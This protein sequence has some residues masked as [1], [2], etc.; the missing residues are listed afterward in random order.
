MTLK[1]FSAQVSSDGTKRTLDLYK[2]GNLIES[3]PIVQAGTE[4]RSLILSTWVKS[5]QTVSTQKWMVNK[6]TY[7]LNEPRV[8]ELFWENSWV[9]T[10]DEEGY[11]VHAWICC[12][13][14]KLFHIY[15]SPELRGCKTATSLI[16]HFCGPGNVDIYKPWPF[17]SRG[18]L[19]NKNPY[20]ILQHP[21]PF[22]TSQES[23]D[24]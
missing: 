17:Q 21:L 8:A 23:L 22:Q 12:L 7:I 2:S 13:P 14:G 9:V 6:E 1:N 20:I 4:H 18:I 19:W 16:K 10:S 15:V 11:T 5:Y 24:K 3:L